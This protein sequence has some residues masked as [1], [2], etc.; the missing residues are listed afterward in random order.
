[1]LTLQENNRPASTENIRQAKAALEKFMARSDI[2]FKD[3]PFRAPLWAESARLGRWLSAQASDLVL[4][5]I[6]GS[7]LGPQ[8]L[9][10]LSDSRLR[11]HFADNVDPWQF[12][13]IS[14]S[15][16]DWSKCYFLVISKS[17]ST[18]ETLSTADLFQAELQK[19]NLNFA[20]QCVVVTEPRPNSLREWAQKQGVETLEIP[21]DVG[22][23]FSILSPV[24]MALAAALGLSLD[25]L[26]EGARLALEDR[27]KVATVA[28]EA[29]ESF[30]RD[31]WIT[32]LWSYSSGLRYFGLWFQQLWAESLAK[33]VD[34]QGKP[35][36]RV[37]T[38]MPAIGTCDQH[39]LLQQVMEGAKDKW[40]VQIRVKEC[41]SGGPSLRQSSF[42]ALSWMKTLKFGDILAAEA[43]ATAQALRE[44]GLSVR[45]MELSDLGPKSIGHLLMFW[46]LVVACIGEAIDIDAFDQPGVELGKRLAKEI[47][48]N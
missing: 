42:S 8:L 35:G 15:I 29:L 1:M 20:K 40:V 14:R 36:P 26:R 32:F 21:V 28:A 48:K 44:S 2:G 41:E 45:T 6:G 3:L 38:P 30:R 18:L 24:G 23:R 9:A 19:R 25:D 12:E 43:Q 4:I 33:K 34:R 31:E 39:S 37:S 46:Q 16:G 17:G 22:G 47:L 27:D 7:S 5:G 10:D 11:V 13:K